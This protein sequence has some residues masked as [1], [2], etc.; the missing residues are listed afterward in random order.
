[1]VQ[2]LRH[3]VEKLRP[4]SRMA[5]VTQ[6][7]AERLTAFR[8]RL[9][10]DKSW[11]IMSDDSYPENPRWLEELRALASQSPAPGHRDARDTHLVLV[12]GCLGPGGAERQWCYLAR[13]LAARGYRVTLLTVTPLEGENAHYLPLLDGTGVRVVD[14]DSLLVSEE[15]SSYQTSKMPIDAWMLAAALDRLQPTHVLSQLDY[16]NVWSGV[17]ALMQRVPPD[18]VLL[19]FRSLNPA[20]Y[21]TYTTYY[22]HEYYRTLC[23]SSRVLLNANSR[24]GGEDYAEWIGFDPQRLGVAHNAVQLPE[25]SPHT[26]GEVRRAFGIDGS[27]QVVLGVLR[28]TSEKNPG[29][30]L[31]VA[32]AVHEKMPDALFL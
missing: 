21:S 18:A 10:F 27:T 7:L 6:R 1:M 22:F 3:L 17:A 29:L 32:R 19:S 12:T 13:E 11:I 31:E 4:A 2:K 15:A 28:L 26:R 14:R 23:G 20:K 30:F 9:Y 25:L 16:T 24:F 8:A 5:A